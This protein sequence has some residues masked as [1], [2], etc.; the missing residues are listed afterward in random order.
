MGR[1]HGVVFQDDRYSLWMHLHKGV[2]VQNIHSHLQYMK[3]HWG[4]VFF[5]NVEQ[6]CQI[7]LRLS[8]EVGFSQLLQR[9]HKWH[10][11]SSLST[12]AVKDRVNR[13]VNTSFY[14]QHLYYIKKYCAQF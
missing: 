3:L 9:C 4:Q 13:H 8:H 6:L 12:G 14:Y 2:P 7:K 11:L 5:Q 1:I 10:S